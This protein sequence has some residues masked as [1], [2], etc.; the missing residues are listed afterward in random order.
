MTVQ[1]TIPGVAD[2]MK[3]GCGKH[4]GWDVACSAYHPCNECQAH[5]AQLDMRI[6]LTVVKRLEANR[7]ELMEKLRELDSQVTQQQRLLEQ[8]GIELQ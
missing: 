2:L 1:N 7:L 3:I 8:S 5:M 6:V 4:M